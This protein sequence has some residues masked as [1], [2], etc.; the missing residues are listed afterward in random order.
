MSGAVTA[1]GG[2]LELRQLS[3]ETLGLEARYK[4]LKERRARRAEIRSVSA[5]AVRSADP[6]QDRGNEVDV[7]LCG[8]LVDGAFANDPRKSKTP[9]TGC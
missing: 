9:G 4:A 1:K 6:A 8:G 7:E 3:A 2:R 5:D